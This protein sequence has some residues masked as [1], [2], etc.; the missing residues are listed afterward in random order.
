MCSPARWPS[1]AGSLRGSSSQCWQSRQAIRGFSQGLGWPV[2]AWEAASSASARAS[3]AAGRN[4]AATSRLSA[5]A[6]GSLAGAS[7]GGDKPSHEPLP[8][9]AAQQLLQGF[10]DQFRAWLAAAAGFV[11]QSALQVIG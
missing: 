2:L 6:D 11:A 4:S 10:A 9:P 7:G 8:L 3:Q 1:I 5:R